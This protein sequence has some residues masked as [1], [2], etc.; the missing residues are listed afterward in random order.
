MNTNETTQNKYNVTIDP[1]PVHSKP[2]E[3]YKMT[4]TSQSDISA[5]FLIG[6]L[7]QAGPFRDVKA[8]PGRDP[9]SVTF[10]LD[11]IGS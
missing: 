8:L 10:Q 5:T 6:L 11:V 3:T 1:R 7:Q 9:K 2:D 4:I